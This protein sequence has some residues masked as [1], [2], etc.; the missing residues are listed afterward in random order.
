MAE[1]DVRFSTATE[2]QRVDEAV[3]GLTVAPDARLEVDGGI[4]RMPLERSEAVI[5]LYERARKL[6][7]D[8]TGSWAMCAVG[9]ASDGNITAGMGLPTLDGLGGA[10]AGLH[11]PDEYVEVASLPQAGRADRRI[12]GRDLSG[13]LWS[14]RVPYLMRSPRCWAASIAAT[15]PEVVTNLPSHLIGSSAACVPTAS[16]RS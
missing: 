14:G 5:G 10:G 8:S 12:A 9:G 16:R 1:L 3:R 7:E 11:T 13:Q 2:A 4:D 6:V 15:L